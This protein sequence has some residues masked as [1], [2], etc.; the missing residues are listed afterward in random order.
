MFGED[1]PSSSD[2]QTRLHTS[3]DPPTLEATDPEP[4][5]VEVKPSSKTEPKIDDD[6]LF[7]MQEEE[8]DPKPK[9]PSS[10]VYGSMHCINYYK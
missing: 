4:V 3:S 6:D 5:A 8:S 1:T 7:G 2:D 9:E 10:Q